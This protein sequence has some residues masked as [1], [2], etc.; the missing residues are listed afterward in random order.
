MLSLPCLHLLLQ[1]R[2]SH[3]SALHNTPVSAVLQN[4]TT[5]LHFHSCKRFSG[6]LS[7]SLLQL[8]FQP[9]LPSPCK[10]FARIFVRPEAIA[11][12]GNAF[13]SPKMATLESSLMFAREEWSKYHLLFASMIFHSNHD[14]QSARSVRP[15]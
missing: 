15:G 9:I 5:L 13:T 1:S 11:K 10:T 8:S 7:K 2:S 14:L 4:I 3:C 12:I 6:V